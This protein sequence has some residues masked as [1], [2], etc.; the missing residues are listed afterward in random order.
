EPPPPPP[1][2]PAAPSNPFAYAATATNSAQANTTNYS[3]ALKAGQTLTI[4]TCGLDDAAFTGDTYL[5]LRDAYNVEV[6]YSDDGC[7]SGYGSRIT[8][9]AAAAGNFV[10]V[11]GCYSS[12]SCTGHVA[13]TI[14]GG[15]PEPDPTQ[16]SFAFSAE[17]TNSARENTVDQYISVTTGQ[18]VTVSTCGSADG[19]TFLRLYSGSRQVASNDDGCAT[20]HGSSLSFTASTTSLLQVR[21]GCYR[22][23]SCSGT[24]QW[25]IE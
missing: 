24:V 23:T 5:R 22:D 20:G 19:D 25:S 2:P 15:E 12:G 17:E 7:G 8:Y 10:I 1:P 16:G 9:T 18:R 13:W 3:I 21:A 11:P 4:G 14:T 6:A